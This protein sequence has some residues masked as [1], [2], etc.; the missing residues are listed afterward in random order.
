MLADLL[1]RIEHEK[2]HGPDPFAI[3]A[4]RGLAE[5]TADWLG[6]LRSR[7]R[8][9]DYVALKKGRVDDI[10]SNCRFVYP[11][12]IAAE[13]VER[14]LESLR[15]GP[16]KL[17]V[18]TTND[19]VQALTNSCGW[20][21]ENERMGRNPLLRVKKGNAENDRRHVR[22]PLMPTNCAGS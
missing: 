17:A 22:P 21:V 19:Y 9:A 8:D 13:P 7:G 15:N 14:Y 1:K 5:H 16:K 11:G 20:M 2:A 12:D 18:Q 6:V 4:K 3:H 10:V